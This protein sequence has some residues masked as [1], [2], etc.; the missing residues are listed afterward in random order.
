[1]TFIE[2]IIFIFPVKIKAVNNCTSMK[3]IICRVIFALIDYTFFLLLIKR[4]RFLNLTYD[5]LKE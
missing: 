1:M 4:T 5:F 3:K 2:C